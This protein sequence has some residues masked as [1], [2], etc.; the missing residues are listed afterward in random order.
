[1]MVPGHVPTLMFCES[2]SPTELDKLSPGG[3]GKWPGVLQPGGPTKKPRQSPNPSRP[4]NRPAGL[5]GFPFVDGLSEFATAVC[6]VC[7]TAPNLVNE[8]SAFFI[9]FS[10]GCLGRADCPVRN[11]LVVIG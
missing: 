3:W 4:A 8:W 1:M 5:S 2:D 11:G 6:L 7:G 9:E 10:S